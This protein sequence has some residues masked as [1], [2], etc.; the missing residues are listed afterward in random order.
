MRI[1]A[2]RRRR[3]VHVMEVAMGDHARA[4]AHRAHQRRSIERDERRDQ[5]KKKIDGDE[6]SDHGHEFTT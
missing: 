3:V 1:C 6:L 5:R 4:G 2:V